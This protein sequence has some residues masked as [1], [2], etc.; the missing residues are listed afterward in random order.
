M[1]GTSRIWRTGLLMAAVAL[2]ALPAIA[3]DQPIVNGGN[4]RSVDLGAMQV[5]A[6]G[7]GTFAVEPIEP[8]DTVNCTTLCSECLWL[9]SFNA[10]ETGLPLINAVTTTNVLASGTLHMIT[11]VGTN[12]WWPDN[13]YWWDSP[14]CP[15]TGKPEN[16]P[17]YPSPGNPGAPTPYVGC[18]W[19]YLF[20][21]PNNCYHGDFLKD[22]AAA[23]SPNQNISLDGGTTWQHLVPWGGQAYNSNHSY[24]YLVVGQGKKASF[25]ILDTGPHSDNYGQYHICI[26]RVT[27]CGSVTNPS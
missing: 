7:I 2:L 22:G 21:Y 1:T 27:F 14:G 26:Q 24:S 12:S 23:S 25:R 15:P 8:G 5:L 3:A 18:D 16:A 20:A 10:T 6:P 4:A 11:I 17:I 19:E 13:Q 9:D